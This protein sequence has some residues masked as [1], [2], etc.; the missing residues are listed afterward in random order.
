MNLSAHMLLS[1]EVAGAMYVVQ[2]EHIGAMRGIFRPADL[3]YPDE[4]GRPMLTRRLAD[5]FALTDS[6]APPPTRQHALIVPT[7]RRS[8]ALLVDRVDELDLSG[9]LINNIQPLPDVLARRLGRPWFSG[10]LV[11]E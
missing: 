2:R 10:V 9:A 4:H 6:A 11:W 5:L 8:V 3:E 1:V 7:R